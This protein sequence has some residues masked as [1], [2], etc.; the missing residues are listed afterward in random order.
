M[1]TRAA[2]AFA[3]KKPLEIV[4]LPFEGKKLIGYLQ[5]PP[6]VAKPPVVL[7]WGGVDGWKEDRLRIVNAV[8]AHG[9]ES[10]ESY[11]DHT[12]KFAFK[13]FGDIVKRMGVSSLGTTA[14]VSS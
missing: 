9:P 4:E 11:D 7:H 10:F 5:K 13:Y 8:L 1:K 2:V 3:A 6:G 14:R 12:M